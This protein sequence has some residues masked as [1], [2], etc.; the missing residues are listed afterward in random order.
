VSESALAKK[1]KLR[2]GLRATVIG[3]PYGYIAELEPL[4]DGVVLSTDLS[5]VYDWLQ[6]FVSD[7]AALAAIMPAAEA[8][9]APDATLWL[10]FPKGSSK[11]QTDLTRDK[12][13][14]AIPQDRL[15][16]LTLVSINATWSA[17]ALRPYREGEQRRSREM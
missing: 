4:P 12:G 17:F 14:E 16:W 3:A 2:P 10:S 9:L 13:W 11:I 8:A 6:M 5:G 1:L 7:S 15:R